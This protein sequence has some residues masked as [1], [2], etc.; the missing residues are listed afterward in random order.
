MVRIVRWSMGNAFQALDSV[1]YF[2]ITAEIHARSLA[3]FYGQYVDR[4]M[5]LKFMRHVSERER[6]T[7]QF[8]TVKNKVMSVCNASAALTMLRRNS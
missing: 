1:E 8:V 5:N 3:N 7:R 4:H 6:A 2:T